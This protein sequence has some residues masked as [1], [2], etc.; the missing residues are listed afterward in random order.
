[1]PIT[2][3]TL[4]ADLSATGLTMKVTS[5]SSGFP[6][7]GGNPVTPGY[8][9]R[10]D[11][12]YFLAVQQPVA[13]VIKIAQ[14]GYNG[15]A[16]ASHDILSYVEVSPLGSDFADPSP[17]NVVSLPPGL[18]SMQTIGENRTFTSAEIAAWGNQPQ[19][20]VFTKGSAATVVLVAPSK[21][22]DGLVLTFTSAVPYLNVITAT[23]LLANGATASPYT[24]ATGADSKIGASITLQAQNGLWNVVANVGFTLS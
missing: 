16:A 23:A 8:L 18:P 24:T 14:R 10:I 21:A 15:T 3:T 20:F 11:K 17:G 1:M 13:G 6:T 22:Q 7:A 4:A 9:C 19:N 12:E 2:Q 5:G